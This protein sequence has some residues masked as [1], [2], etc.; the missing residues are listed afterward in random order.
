MA[1]LFKR[2]VGVDDLA[3]V[4]F[5]WLEWGAES[6]VAELVLQQKDQDWL[7]IDDFYRL[8]LW[9]NNYQGYRII[10]IVLKL[11]KIN[12]IWKG[13]KTTKNV[14]ENDLVLWTGNQTSTLTNVSQR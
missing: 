3:K 13:K 10:Q 8:F 4:S 11:I 6:F 9:R 1:K 12:K 14:K 2:G 7:R 5:V